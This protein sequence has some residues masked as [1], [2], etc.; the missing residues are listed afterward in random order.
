MDGDD[1]L[2]VGGSRPCQ[3]TLRISTGL[4]ATSITA[5]PVYTHYCAYMNVAQASLAACIASVAA[6]DAASP[7]F[8]LLP[9]SCCHTILLA[10]N[11]YT[12]KR[13]DLNNPS[14]S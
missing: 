7:L 4:H 14:A 5:S 3:G 8:A 9:S 12:T 11:A 6:G 10:M 13:C 1:C 2:T